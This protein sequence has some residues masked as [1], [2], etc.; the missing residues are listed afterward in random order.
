MSAR[1]TGTWLPLVRPGVFLAVAIGGASSAAW[2]AHASVPLVWEQARAFSWWYAAPAAALTLASVA[3][4]FLRWQFLLRRAGLRLPVRISGAIYVAGLAMLLTP[5]YAGEGVKT[6]LVGRAAGG[7]YARAAG[8][9]VA[10]RLFDAVALALAGGMALAVAPVPIGP[11]GA[12][13]RLGPAL[14]AAGAAGGA[15]LALAGTRLPAIYL[16]LARLR[17]GLRPA[18]PA[19]T[20]GSLLIALALSLCAWTLGS[21]TLAVVCAGAGAGVGA[22]RA[23]GIYAASTLL[24]GLTLLPAG[25]GVVG[26]AIVLHLRAGGVAEAQAVLAAALVRLLTVWLTAAI[27]IG[28]CWRLWR[29]GGGAL[30]AAA[31]TEAERFEALAP[32]YGEQLSPLARERVVARKVRVML[33][34]LRRAG[35]GAGSRILDAGCGQ[36]WYAG[37]LAGRGYR[38]VGIDVAVAQ[39]K[40]ARGAAGDQAAGAALAAAS[41]LNLPFAA[42]TFDAAYAVNLL[43]HLGDPAAQELALAELA[44]VVRPGGLVFVHEINTINPLFRLYMSYLFPLW[45]E[46]DLG[47]EAWLDPRRLPAPAPLSLAATDCYT[48]LPDF[49]PRPVFR[50]LRALEARLEGTRW[51]SYGA[52]F[53]AIYQRGDDTGGHDE[54]GV[55]RARAAPAPAGASR[56]DEPRA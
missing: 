54:A 26:T 47:T 10:E 48:F 15:L 24:G 13:A 37:A 30:P 51:K 44:R 16:A 56:T 9:V 49:T 41:V 23:A 19:I 46:I 31:P 14:L 3:L 45:R 1:R 12:G 52:H 5:A 28:G 38:V 50:R 34:A 53:T 18:P 7:G 6:W 33:P 43:H 35:I 39:L 22:L 11:G 17:G 2:V 29:R 36:G 20:G 4:R 32:A 8:V 40:A 21:L 55:A 42:H 25:A 27:G